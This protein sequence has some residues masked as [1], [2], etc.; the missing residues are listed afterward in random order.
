MTALKEYARLESGGLWRADADAQR[1][2]VIVSFGDATLV[3]SDS[4]ERA[5]A[6]WSPRGRG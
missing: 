6:H 3:I 5:L 2:D 4:A 1:R